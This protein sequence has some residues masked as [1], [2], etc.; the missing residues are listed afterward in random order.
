MSETRLPRWGFARPPWVNGTLLGNEKPSWIPW[1]LTSSIINQWNYIDVG[2]VTTLCWRRGRVTTVW[3]YSTR[4]N[5]LS[6]S[7][8]WE[9]YDLNDWSGDEMTTR[10]CMSMLPA[11]SAD[12]TECVT[13][14]VRCC[15]R[16]VM[17]ESQRLIEYCFRS[18]ELCYIDVNCFISLYLP[19]VQG[20]L[21]VCFSF[22][23]VWE[24]HR[25]ILW[26]K[27]ETKR[28]DETSKRKIQTAY[29]EILS[30]H[31]N[32]SLSMIPGNRFI[33]CTAGRRRSSFL[34][35]NGDRNAIDS[36]CNSTWD[37]E[38]CTIAILRMK[39]SW[40]LRSCAKVN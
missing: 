39:L 6:A 1:S 24:E 38:T 34:S 29:W 13:K 35:V 30:H 18:I 10:R 15:S 27:T 26:V 3:V 20:F 12:S 22:S 16:S 14:M 32:C 19:L 25:R 4:R 23:S 36:K 37:S 40:I 9:F 33:Q 28:D 7:Q 31:F 17:F 8:L 11:R 2:T 5:V 21:S